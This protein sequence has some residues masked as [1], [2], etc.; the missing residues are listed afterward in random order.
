M[1]K[2]FNMS[3]GRRNVMLPDVAPEGPGSSEVAR[4]RSARKRPKPTRTDS[5]SSPVVCEREKS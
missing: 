1:D 4:S 3:D 2:V 5:K